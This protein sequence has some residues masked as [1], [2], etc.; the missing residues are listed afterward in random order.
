[1]PGEEITGTN[2]HVGDI[3]PSKENPQDNKWTALRTPVLK[4][5]QTHNVMAL[6]IELLADKQGRWN[7][8][9][10]QQPHSAGPSLAVF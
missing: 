5:F 3:R 10:L 7:L 9:R 1:M 6:N 4:H 2:C 8:T